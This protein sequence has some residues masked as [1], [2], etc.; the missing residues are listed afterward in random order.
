[1]GRIWLFMPRTGESDTINVSVIAESSFLPLKQIQALMLLGHSNFK[2]LNNN[3]IERLLRLP[4]TTSYVF[5]T[6]M[7]K[8]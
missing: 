5:S 7:Y 2:R 8:E 6:N 1:M 4:G 3:E